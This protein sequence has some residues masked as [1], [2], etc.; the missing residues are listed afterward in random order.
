[1]D[2][3]VSR[4][5][6]LIALEV[7]LD[8]AS[9]IASVALQ[10]TLPAPLQAYLRGEDDAPQRASEIALRRRRGDRNGDDV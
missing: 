9:L 2:R 8:V 1:M 5:R 3:V 7:G 10:R 4:F 6:A